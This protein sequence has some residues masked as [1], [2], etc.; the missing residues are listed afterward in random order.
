MAKAYL[1]EEML[2]HASNLE[3]EKA[4]M[5]K[6]KLEFLEDYQVKHTVVNPSI[7]DVDVFGMVS[8]ETAAYINYF[9]IRNG[10][11]VQSYTS[12]FRKN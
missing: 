6:E 7:D 9:K 11:I 1:E 4:Q 2:K 10:N 3:F 12:E 8:D 5:V